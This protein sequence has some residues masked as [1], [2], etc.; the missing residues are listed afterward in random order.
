M[1]TETYSLSLAPQD[2]WTLVAENP[3]YLAIRS[4]DG[5]PWQLAVLPS[6]GIPGEAPVLV[7]KPRSQ[8]DGFMFTIDFPTAGAFYVRATN[9]A[10]STLDPTQISYLLDTVLIVTVDSTAITV[11]TTTVTCDAI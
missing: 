7:F 11:D 2:G 4:Q 6:I 5:K 3:R 9:S 10:S 1:A 8:D